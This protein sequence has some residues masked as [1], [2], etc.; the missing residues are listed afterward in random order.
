MSVDPADGR[1][2]TIVYFAIV[3]EYSSREQPAGV[4]CR[5]ADEAGVR[6]EVF[7]RNLAWGH[8]TA[9]YAED[10]D[11][12]LHDITARQ[13]GEITSRMRREAARA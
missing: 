5:I 13:A 1:P 9:R 7:G 11:C 3:D 8:V 6:T 10:R 12:E 4:L 2:A